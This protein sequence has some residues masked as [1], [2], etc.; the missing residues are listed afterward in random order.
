MVAPVT[1]RRTALPERVEVVVVG[2]GSAGAVVAARLSERPEVSVLLLEAGPDHGRGDPPVEIS[3]PSFVAAM[4]LPG[5]TWEG[6]TATRTAVQ[7]PRPYPRGRGVGGSSAINAMVALPGEPDDYDGWERDHGC[8]GWGWRELAPWFARAPVP[9]RHTEVHERG[10]LAT[11]LL[12]AEPTAFA[13]PLT[14]FADG[15]RA[16]TEAVYLH[17]ARDR[18][19]LTVVGDALVD[20][21]LF[22]GRRASGVRLADGRE[23]GAG[24]VVVCAGAIHSPALLLRSA[25]D[26]AGLGEGLHDHPSFPLAIRLRERTPSAPDTPSVSV[27]ARAT[28]LARNDLQLIALDPLVP[29]PAADCADGAADSADSFAVLLAAAMHVHSRGRVRLVSPDPTVNPDVQFDMLSDDRD[30]VAL[31]AAAR[32]GERFATSATVTALGELQPYDLSDDGLRRSIGDYVHAAGTCR[33]GL[34]ADEAAV[35]DNTCRVIGYSGLFVCDASVFPALPRANPHLS[36]VV[37]AE[38][39]AD[40]LAA[41]LAD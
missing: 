30:V 36:V 20:R 35:V 27:G 26:R 3:G 19:N 40:M 37:V 24:A 4:A 25:V 22:A 21:V 14:R 31:C 9:V 12:A 23:V 8:V 1:P 2:A 5:R 32:L 34:A 28:H 39:F 7:G 38:R 11:A 29:A 15:R 10:A 13:L 16:D 18:G 41:G 33:M 17:P 6:L